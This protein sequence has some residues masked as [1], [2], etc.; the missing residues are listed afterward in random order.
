MKPN[1]KIQIINVKG[2]TCTGCERT[3]EKNLNKIAGIESAKANQAKGTVTVT[4]DPE[5]LSVTVI[6]NKICALGYRI[7][8][9]AADESR[10]Q[11]R[12]TAG[13][14]IFLAI[15]YLV[16][17]Y[18]GI[19]GLFRLFPEAKTGMGYGMIFVIGL[20]TSVHCVA[21]CG[22][23]NLSQC[24]GNCKKENNDNKLSFEILKADF[25]YHAGRVCS[26]TL[27]GGLI[28]AAGAVIS[29]SG[30]TKGLIQLAAG[31]FM[32]IMGLNMLQLIPSLSRFMPRMPKVFTKNIEQ[33]KGRGPFY[34]GLLN[35]FM[36][37][38]PLQAM[39]LYALS[40]GSMGK[41]AL[42]MLLFSLGTVPLLFIIGALSTVL[43]QKYTKKILSAGALMVVMMGTSMV[44][45]GLSLTGVT[46]AAPG[47]DGVMAE[48]PVSE[49]DI[50]IVNT[51]LSPRSYEPIVVSQGVPVR[52]TIT[53]EPGTI[54]GCNNRILI[55]EYQIEKRLQPGENI[56][57][58]TPTESG[59]FVYSCW[60]GM[61]RSSI[62]VD[63][64]DN[65]NQQ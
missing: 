23:I 52:W 61:I 24:M 39:Q 4:Y 25:L 64:A 17:K 63:P 12:R 60:M 51:S 44:M 21:M 38:G 53:A 54:N 11:V 2:M 62:T 8:L 28:G 19:G 35:G 59:K 48:Q 7:A 49:H 18:S 34:V 31:I 10:S 3:I 42:A 20:L 37:C 29:F 46:T 26:Y 58:F 41:G 47:A 50:Q 57:E 15:G 45:N 30:T 65:K 16:F 9:T 22:G 1:R 40:T 27:L 32:I 5:Q 43:T 36:P 55:P 33:Q 14:A 13:A 56:I 6:E